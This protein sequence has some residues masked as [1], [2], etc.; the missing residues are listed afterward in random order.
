MVAHYRHGRPTIGVLAGWQF[1][2]T[3]TNLSYLAPLSRGI[4]RAAQDLGCNVMLACGMGPSASPT[5]PLRPA[6]PFG[7]SE[8]DFL[9]VGPWNTDGLIVA[10]PLRSAARS[11]YVQG[12]M[13]AGHPV[14]FIGA[15]E[16]G[17]TIAADSEGGI[18]E[19]LRHL[20][21]HGHHRIAFIAGTVEDMR[22][23][24]G[25]RLR[26]YMRGCQQFGLSAE[27]DLIAYG[28]HVYDGGYTA[29]QE[30]LRRGAAFSAVLASNDESALG[31]MQALKEAGLR[32]PGDVAVIG[33][34]NRLED[35]V[36]E[37]GL[38]SVHVPLFNVGYHAVEVLLA[39]M[40]GK[41]QLPD[42]VKVETRL[43]RRES[44]G[45]GADEPRWA[46]DLA[47]T[48]AIAVM[49]QAHNLTEEE[50]LALSQRLVGAYT[51]SLGDGNPAGFGRALDEALA[52]TENAEDD[53]HI[54]QAAITIL[55]KTPA[56]S[57]A[58]RE[59]LSDASQT[60]SAH[61]RRQH[62]KYVV[63]ERLSTSR[64]S[65]LTARLLTAL[66]ER[67]I[68]RILGDHLPEMGLRTAMLGMFELDEGD[69]YAR[70][71]MRNLLDPAQELAYFRSADFPPPELAARESQFIFTLIPLVDPTGQVGFMVFDTGHFDLYGSIVQQVSSALNTARLY[72]QATEARLVAEEANRMKSRFLSTISHEL[73]TPLNLIMGLSGMAARDSEENDTPLP[74]HIHKDVNLI[75]A[76]S[77]HLGG[78][79]GDVIDLATSDA[80][81]LRL[82]VQ[83]MDMSQALR[84][85]AESGG[86][87]AADKGLSWDAQLPESGAW[88]M[89]DQTRLR[90]VALNLIN[91][92]IKF[93]TTGGVRLEV[94]QIG[95]AVVVSVMDTGL[96]IS[97][98]DQQVI[99][100][101]FRQS[102]RSVARGYGGLGVGLAISKRLVEMHG[103]QIQVASSGQDNAGSV[104]SFSL[105][106]IAPPEQLSQRDEAPSAAQNSTVL[107]KPVEMTELTATLDQWWLMA[108]G[109]RATRT[110]LV[111]DD[112]PGALDMNARIVQAHSASNRVLKASNGKAALDVLRRESVDLILLD[113]QMP[114]MDGFEF[115]DAMRELET[116]RKIPVIV[117]TGKYLTE[118]DM[119]RLNQ[120]ISAVLGKGL[121][122]VDET[123]AHIGAALERK[124]RL[125]GEARRLVRR[126]MAYLHQHFAEAVSRKDIARHVGITEDH[127]TF[128]FRQELGTTPIEYLQRYRI[129]QAKRLL[130]E[131]A[132]PITEVALS[133]GFSD[134][135]Y[136]SRIFHRET[137]VSPEA[138]RKA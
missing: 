2:R 107:T 110:V 103:G 92:A 30:L 91:N 47:R 44:C 99:F 87:L 10:N 77:Q 68:Y 55:G 88:V 115:L 80:G 64:L 32:I 45:C 35:M 4:S 122:S 12:L 43:I 73:R 126:A 58:L 69:P 9:P 25:D 34:D 31:A 116:A 53:A 100:D 119:Q 90:Q 112:E 63:D 136:F 3:A 86:Q 74:E 49:N 8:H 7:S 113:L 51:A 125:S 95:G 20:V 66:D 102:E 127:L 79:I 108:D 41:R 84:M 24:S 130:L 114:E 109:G 94:E 1:Y 111:V 104:F 16:K 38:S 56:A 18:L 134:S 137:G 121:F 42:L 19:A 97:P 50:V 65:L 129:N 52:R 98:Q 82:N 81:Q 105:P 48:I 57:P 85:A 131:T 128:C 120:G 62:R 39:Q 26:A 60:I 71:A 118:A 124:R 133:V 117:L 135:G 54:W 132:K 72:R 76:Y 15:G 23:D 33:F 36:Q 101:E 123:V 5:D 106:A 70:T 93:T 89:G 28:R 75:H 13:A 17:P 40:A 138:F 29:M 96:G 6:W 14:L 83:P 27:P 22:G 78:L 67:Q 46:D 59:F 37:P 11:E 21:D 61:M